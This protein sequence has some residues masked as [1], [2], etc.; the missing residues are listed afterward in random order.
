MTLHQENRKNLKKPNKKSSIFCRILQNLTFHLQTVLSHLRIHH[1][2]QVAL[3]GLQIFQERPP[4]IHLQEGIKILNLGQAVT[5]VVKRF[6]VNPIRMVMRAYEF[7][8]ILSI[9]RDNGNTRTQNAPAGWRRGLGCIL[10]SFLT[11]HPY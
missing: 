2:L 7:L 4:L 10:L 5:S 3:K 8:L 1:S 11:I 6:L 9:Q